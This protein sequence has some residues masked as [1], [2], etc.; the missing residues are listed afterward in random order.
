MM[1]VSRI[2][3]KYKVTESAEVR[4]RC[5][6]VASQRRAVRGTTALSDYMTMRKLS[7]LGH[8]TM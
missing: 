4:L 3:L 6:V 2:F 5:A 7:Q 1:Q 8:R